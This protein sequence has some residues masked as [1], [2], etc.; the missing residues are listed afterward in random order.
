M[1]EISEDLK[2]NLIF[3]IV[4]I[5]T[6]KIVTWFQLGPSG[7]AATNYTGP[8]VNPIPPQTRQERKDSMIRNITLWR[9]GKK[10]EVRKLT[11]IDSCI[12]GIAILADY[13]GTPEEVAEAYLC[14]E[15][16]RPAIYGHLVN[17][18]FANGPINYYLEKNR[19]K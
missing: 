15:V 4:F 14:A 19:K 3:G 6:Y 10:D 2:S 1:Y 17:R 7:R 18:Y 5:V 13:D 12:R 9:S 8:I 16:L 11:S